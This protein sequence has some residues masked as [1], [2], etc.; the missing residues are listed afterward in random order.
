MS[1][2]KKK[3]P[4]AIDSA[5]QGEILAAYASDP[6]N[7]IVRHALSRHAVT[8]VFYDPSH[9]PD[10]N[11]SYSLELSTMTPMNQK[12]SGRCW[13]YAGLGFMRETIAK[14]LGI[15]N[16]QLSTNYIALYDKIEKSNYALESCL[17]YADREKD[18]RELKWLLANP[19][20]DGGQWD[21]LVNL[22]N[23]YGLMPMEAFPDTYQSSNTRETDWVVNCYIRNFA[24]KAWHLVHEGKAEEAREL[25]EKTLE[26]I[27]GLF[28][29][30]FGVP[31]TTF[32]FEYKDSEDA[33]HVVSGLTPLEFKKAY[34]GD[35]LD[36]YVSLIN[37][38]TEDKPYLKSYTIDRLGNV[39]EGKR[40][41]HLNVTMERMKELILKQLKDGSPVWFGSDVSFYR[42]RN[43][44][45]WDDKAI[46]YEGSFGLSVEES[47]EN[48]LDFSASAMNHAM[49]IVG[50]NLVENVPTKWK[51]E[52][53][54]G[55]DNG[56]QGYY[57]MSESWFDK[58]VYQ[59]VVHK[60]YL[61]SEELKAY[62][63]EPIVLKPWDPMGTLAD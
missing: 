17:Y 57:A 54:W 24:A 47:K 33:R 30:A 2:V 53:S 56:Q 14:K 32:D 36:D 21:M 23:K 41:T 13:I 12:A 45:A 37:S 7:A 60:K 9:L 51:I 6:K 34:L 55:T 52:N 28:L 10:V 22:V 59:A 19:V 44:F 27:Y 40:V 62:L 11:M 48:M 4:G 18:D 50:V 31:P 46:D 5:R 1:S 43:S 29:S 25:K 42:D 15:K 63:E 49:L 39:L 61:S 16:F 35:S 58:F 20:S 3:I 38:P 8:S 26:K